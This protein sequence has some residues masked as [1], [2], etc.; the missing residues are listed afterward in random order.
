MILGTTYD[1]DL[2]EKVFIVRGSERYTHST[3][4]TL[5]YTYNAGNRSYITINLTA[6]VKNHV[7]ESA[8]VF[9]DGVDV[10]GTV[11]CSSFDPEVSITARVDY[12]YHKFYAKYMGNSACLS[13]KSGIEEFNVNTPDLTKSEIVMDTIAD[14]YE[15]GYGVEIIGRLYSVS[16]PRYPLYN[17]NVL[18]TI[19]EYEEFDGN[20]TTN[21]SGEFRIMTYAYE[22][23]PG[24]YHVKADFAGSDTH[25]GYVEEFTFVV[26]KDNCNI[27]VVPKFTKIGVG[28][29]ANFIVTAKTFKDAPIENE[30][31][32][33]NKEE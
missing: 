21:G 6:T 7:G 13:S 31:V 22:L 10:L 15:E 1:P 19:D 8:V 28:D 33:L 3:I 27:T 12:G 18:V 16:S 30:T 26:A 9:Y 4:T 32:T 20:L 29:T 5:A 24:T 2:K 14:Y 23:E 11:D 17:E 25:L